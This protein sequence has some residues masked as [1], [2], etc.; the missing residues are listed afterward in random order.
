[1]KTRYRQVPGCLKCDREIPEYVPG[2]CCPY[3]GGT[4]LGGDVDP[5]EFVIRER[6]VPQPVKWW[7]P[8][9]WSG[10][11]WCLVDKHDPESTT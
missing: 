2:S 5:H 1:M 8:F 6:W 11:R 3:C 9:T 7:N 10:G 4:F